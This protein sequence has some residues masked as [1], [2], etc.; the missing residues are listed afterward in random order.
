MTCAI[1]IPARYASKRFK[2]KVLSL[3]GKKPMLYYVY[4]AAKQSIFKPK[5]YITTDDKRIL[6]ECLKFADP[7][8][9][10]LSS[11]NI[12]SGSDRCAELAKTIKE[13]YLINIQ[14]DEPLIKSSLIDKIIKELKN[15]DSKTPVLTV[16]K[17]R[18]LPEFKKMYFDKNLVKVIFNKKN[19]A[20]YFS[21]TGLP[22]GKKEASFFYQHIGIYAYRKDFLI[23]FKS[24]K[25][26]FYEKQEDLEQLR[27]LENY[28]NIRVIETK[29]ELIGVDLRK[30]LRKV[31]KILKEKGSLYE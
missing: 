12:K 11:K 8:E 26:S 30:D 17:K 15:L 23:K 7:S 13:K 10:V 4:K 9:V 16:A 31:K 28:Y 3:I 19:N 24:F 5:V 25:R 2:A 29:D 1:V 20:I 6:N 14:A 21:R 27:V 18:A 22:S